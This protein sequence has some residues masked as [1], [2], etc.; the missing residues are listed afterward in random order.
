MIVAKGIR[1]LTASLWNTTSRILVALSYY[2]VGNNKIGFKSY[3][4]RDYPLRP[5]AW[6]IPIP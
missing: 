6:A 5:T 1:R 3:Q 2:Y 4:C